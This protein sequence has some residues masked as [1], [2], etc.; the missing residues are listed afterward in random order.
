M[1]RSGVYTGTDLEVAGGSVRVDESSKVRRAGTLVVAGSTDASLR[2]EDGSLV[3]WDAGAF[4]APVDT[5]VQVWV[6]HRYTESDTEL[7]PVLMGRVSG[8]SRRGLSDALSLELGDYSAVLAESRFPSPWVT[9]VGVT[10][11]SEITRIVRDVL[12]WV[13]VYDLTGSSQVTSA[14]TWE[15]QR[16]DAVT[17]LATSMAA[18]AF[19]DPLGRLILRAVPDGSAAPVWTMDTGTETAIVE[20]AAMSVDTSKVY[21]AVSVSSSDPN[22]SDVTAIVYQTSG[23][24]R[25]RAGF[26]RCRFFAS[27]VLKTREACAAAAATLLPKSLIYATRVEPTIAPDPALEA[28]DTGTLTLP[29]RDPETRVLAGF[30]VPLDAEGQRMPCVLRSGAVDVASTDDLREI[31]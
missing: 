22:V 9:P 1:W 24:L 26:Q 21:N 29:D 18:E 25:W 11:V 15:R 23:D 16:W 2:L 17:S 27:P 7:V 28:G 5:D 20:D 19:F 3:P 12:P 30:T 31:S 10:V 13:E 4:L 14:A 8:V 6:G